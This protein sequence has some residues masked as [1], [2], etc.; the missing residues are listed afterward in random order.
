[1]TDHRTNLSAVVIAS[2]EAAN[3]RRSLPQL[4]RV[5]DD[6][7][8]VDACSTDETES[9]C[10]GMGTRFLKREWQGYS[11]AKNFGNS[12]AAHDWIIS[13]DA[14]EVLSN[15]LVQSIIALRPTKGSVYALDRITR[16]CGVWI[17]HSGWY[18]D[19]SIRI[20]NRSDAWWEKKHVHERLVIPWDTRVVRLEGKLF[21]YSYDTHEDYVK[22]SRTLRRTFR[23]GSIRA[24]GTS[25]I[26]VAPYSPD[27]P[28]SAH[29]SAETRLHGR[30]R[31]AGD[32]GLERHKWSARDTASLPNFEAAAKFD[33]GASRLNGCDLERRRAANRIS[34]RRNLFKRGIDQSI[35]F[36][37]G[38]E[39][40]RYFRSAGTVQRMLAEA[41]RMGPLWCIRA[42]S[43]LR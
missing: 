20:F 34:R 42:P 11:S 1:M 8:V 7:V 3:L 24:G 31:G 36:P 39:T 15:Q 35:L 5:S 23:L 13:I 37:T 10:R 30:Q 19:W 21:H 22:A 33:E 9:I 28:F 27:R 43:R 14:D 18:P 12:A 26:S 2:N 29:L 4:T 6:V 40:E 16:F 32:R 17:R 25:L 38:S 41:S